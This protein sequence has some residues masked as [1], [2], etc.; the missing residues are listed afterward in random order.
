[1]SEE[2]TIQTRNDLEKLRQQFSDLNN[3]VNEQLRAIAS[4]RSSEMAQR[5]SAILRLITQ[6]NLTI[7]ALARGVETQEKERS[8]LRAMQEV[9]A[10]INSF[11]DQAEVLNM[12]IDTI[13]QLTGAE[14]AFLM[15]FDEESGE[16]EVEVARNINRETIGGSSFEISRSIVKSVAESGEPVVTTNAQADPRFAGQESIISYNLRSILCVPL[17]IKDH[18]IGVIY[19]DN[20]IVSGIF[21]DTDR[22]L[23]AA[24]ANQ[25][26]VA[27]EN[28]RLFRQIRQQLADITEMKNLQDDV[29]ESIA[30]GVITID[31]EDKIS[32]Y[33]RAAERVL[34]VPSHK[35]L[36]LDYRLLL[37]APMGS[38]AET[39]IEEVQ[40]SGGH[41]NIELDAEIGS[42]RG[43]TTLNLTISPLLD[44]QQ[45][46]LGVALV[47]DDVS[48][49]KRMESV[50]RYLPPALVDQV[51][52][53][54]AAQQPQRREISVVFADIRGF[55]TV[56]EQWEPEF[57][58]Q[59]LN[60]H[61][62]VAAEAINE[63]EGLIDKY[64]GDTVMALYNTPL[65]PQ[66]DH[67]ERA[68][69]TA[70]AMKANIAEYHRSI[71][72]EQ[73]L[74]FGVGVHTGEAVVGNVGSPL[75]K[76]YSAIGDAINVSSRLQELADGEQ[77]LLSDNTY[78][79][80]RETVKVTE[81]EPVSIRGR[82]APVKVFQL[83]GLL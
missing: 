79:Q 61:L 35:A 25:A 47:F 48:E 39:I 11:L 82:K 2:T 58:I 69:R 36:D 54:D 14:R 5:S 42:R 3:A 51:R 56:S 26:A 8:Q 40:A 73:R 19:T 60:Q 15:L 23:L 53:V 64:D 80:V 43:A 18:T 76:D 71:P 7:E 81:L 12:V 70:L 32:L 63:E 30:S 74:F 21:V 24:F 67:V 9:G 27:I 59:V 46:T 38:V 55:T 44:I 49:K 6:A 28:A 1:M 31:L 29:F 13:I 16:L 41:Y 45:Q 66:E 77:I 65:N 33:N 17:K 78:E 83:D 57:L 50:R 62:T 75:R 72:A 10:A 34:G 52:D 37:E 20:R 4:A 22:D 68:V